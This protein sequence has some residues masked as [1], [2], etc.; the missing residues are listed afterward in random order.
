MKRNAFKV[1]V[2]VAVVAAIGVLASGCSGKEGGRSGGSGEG[3]AS[4]DAGSVGKV[5]ATAVNL[6]ASPTTDFAYRLNDAGNGVVITRYSGAGGVVVIPATIEGF[7]VVELEGFGGKD[8]VTSLVIPNGV[9]TIGAAFMRMNAL[10][11]VVIPA[12]VTVIGNSAFWQSN[13]LTS[14]SIPDSV[15]IIGESAFSSMNALTRINL[16]ASLTQIGISA[17]ARNANLTELI[18][19]DSIE[20]GQI[21]PLQ[22]PDAQTAHR[23]REAISGEGAGAFSGSTQ[24]LSLATRQRLRDLGFGNIE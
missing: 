11:S 7:P 21:G 10:T 12:S 18:I 24:K 4:V 3:G 14:V 5:V 9:T 13:A 23:V 6:A 2:I 15:T 17:F 8:T 20:S 1:T 16:P 22:N 19:P